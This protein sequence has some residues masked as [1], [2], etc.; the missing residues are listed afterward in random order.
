MPTDFIFNSVGEV[1]LL[2]TFT[3]LCF[4]DVLSGAAF[5][6]SSTYRNQEWYKE[7]KKLVWGMPPWWVFPMVWTVL[8]LLIIASLQVFY[9]AAATA[10]A[11][12]EC[13][14]TVTLL[15]FSNLVVNKL[16]TPTFFTMHRP[17]WAFILVLALLATN[18]AILYFMYHSN[19]VVSF[20]LFMPYAVW[21]LYALY[22]NGAWIWAERRWRKS[23]RISSGSSNN[24]Q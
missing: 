23:K 19:Y 14:D 6:S 20:G 7:T 22:L 18:V 4:C 2:G 8:Y 24:V 16:W 3:L 15:A 13:V 11:Y 17:R 21:C 9:R 10:D 1:A 12:G 5:T